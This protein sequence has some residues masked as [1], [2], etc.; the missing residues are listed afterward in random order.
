MVRRAAPEYEDAVWTK[1]V[2]SWGIAIDHR[3]DGK[4]VW[5]TGE[6]HAQTSVERQEPVPSPRS[7]REP[8][9]SSRH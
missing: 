8:L 5:R 6:A 7:W 1:D 4:K 3:R 9:S 2:L